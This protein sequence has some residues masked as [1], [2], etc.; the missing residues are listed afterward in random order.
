MKKCAVSQR[1]HACLSSCFSI[2]KLQQWKA[3]GR[4]IIPET[5]CGIA[6]A[7]QCSLT[8]KGQY[9]AALKDLVMLQHAEDNHV[10]PVVK[11]NIV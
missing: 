8:V 9:S 3:Y 6:A 7:G 2:E 1:R 11:A 4:D 10:M 5:V